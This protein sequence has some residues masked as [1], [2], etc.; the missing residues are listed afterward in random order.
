[1]DIKETNPNTIFASF[2]NSHPEAATQFT[3]GNCS[4]E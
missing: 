1:M 4:S 3:T 2:L